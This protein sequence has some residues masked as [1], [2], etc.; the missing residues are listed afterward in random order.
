MVFKVSI[1][2]LESLQDELITHKF[3]EIMSLLTSLHTH[4]S[5][6]VIYTDGFLPRV[7]RIKVTA[8]LLRALESEYEHLKLQATRKSHS[9]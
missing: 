2:I 8:S 3:E 5:T 9:I 4:S 1:A 6:A 7:C